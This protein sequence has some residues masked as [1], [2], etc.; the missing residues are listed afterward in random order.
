MKTLF[1]ILLFAL[2][3]LTLHGA[4]VRFN[5]GYFTSEAAAY[6]PLKITP[7][8]TNL[9]AVNGSQTIV[10]N[11][12]QYP[13]NS[14]G[15]VTVS[16]MA[17]ITY[18][19]E[20]PA[21]NP[22][23][24][25]QITVPNTNAIVFAENITSV[26]TNQP[27]NAYSIP[28][29]DARFIQK[30]GSPTNAQ[31]LTF[32]A[33]TGLYWPSN[34]AA[35]GVSQSALNA[36]NAAL[37]SAIAA[38][39]LLSS[40][41]SYALGT[42]A[43]NHA[44][45]IHILTNDSAATIVSKVTGATKGW[46]VRFPAWEFYLGTNV[47]V[48]PKGI[49]I[50]GA[51][52]G[53]TVLRGGAIINTNGPILVP[54]DNCTIKDL[55]IESTNQNGVV[56]API[57]SIHQNVAGIATQQGCTNV[58]FTRVRTIADS[59]SIY[60][61][62]TNKCEAAFIDCKIQAQWDAVTIYS[63]AS[64]FLEFRN[65]DII[66]IGGSPY[67]TNQDVMQSRCVNL[68]RGHL[69]FVNCLLAATNQIYGFTDS[70][71]DSAPGQAVGIEYKG[72]PASGGFVE[73]LNSAI[74]TATDAATNVTTTD[75]AGSGTL[76]SIGSL[77]DWRKVDSSFKT[78]NTTN[79][80]AVSIPGSA[81]SIAS[82]SNVVGAG[83]I[84]LGG[85]LT[86]ASVTASRAVYWDSLK[87]LVY[88][89][90]TD[91]ELGY[92]SGVTAAI[93]TQLLAG[94]NNVSGLRTAFQ[95]T[96][97]A[98]LITSNAFLVTSNGLIATSNQV[99]TLTAAVNADSN[100][101]VVVSN[102]VTNLKNLQ[103]NFL[104]G[105]SVTLT[106]N[107]T[108]NVTVAVTNAGGYVLEGFALGSSSPADSTTYFP[109]D[110]ITANNIDYTNA[111]TYIPRNGVLKWYEVR[112]RASV[113]ASGETVQHFVRL[114]NATDV[115]EIDCSYAF[116]NV[117]VRT[118]LSQAVTTNDTIALKIVTPAWVTNPTTVRWWAKFYIEF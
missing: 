63:N 117:I 57:G 95:S 13:L 15:Q 75:I 86:D 2:L 88:S 85:G 37:L 110:L 89:T 99:T 67:G 7:S 91:T 68:D 80:Y 58:S 64:H 11:P 33:G 4:H 14:S 84:T 115:G 52:M 107:N 6:Q 81:I 49:S 54:A 77:F 42:D 25:F 1:R 69:K 51:G 93:Q 44:K 3:P 72:S 26:V 106:T 71:G 100:A 16:N 28:S 17:P 105:V 108:T 36:T 102:H 27:L 62:T 56:T 78:V 112:M 118:N 94:T 61:F 43:T 35:G 90:V 50:Q 38:G 87:R 83:S 101:F 20:W 92:L 104:P 53:A 39:D 82:Q 114:N 34:S 66:S 65:C 9:P 21:V 76:K 70:L 111:F 29:S 10:G 47:L 45:V 40:N 96:S 74:I 22:T 31:V 48:L 116:T 12:K 98:F 97:N 103:Q 79:L 73:I 60:V 59:D 55:T 19:C 32:D 41:L 8:P 109:T 30:N 46:E 23:T 113:L 24:T 18:I 5:L